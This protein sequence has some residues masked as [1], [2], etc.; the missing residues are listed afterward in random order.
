MSAWI[1]AWRAHSFGWISWRVSGGCCQ[2]VNVIACP[3]CRTNYEGSRFLVISLVSFDTCAEL[4]WSINIPYAPQLFPFEGLEVLLSF[5][6][7]FILHPNN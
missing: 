7:P 2:V 1:S 4:H 6:T 5:P 3:N